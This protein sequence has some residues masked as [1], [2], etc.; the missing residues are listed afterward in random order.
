M[1]KSDLCEKLRGWG[2]ETRNKYTHYQTGEE[3]ELV[4]RDVLLFDPETTRGK[5]HGIVDIRGKKWIVTPEMIKQAEK[6][7]ENGYDLERTDKTVYQIG[8]EQ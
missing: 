8:R 4:L 3:L 2:K 5:V 7:L 1:R 6:H